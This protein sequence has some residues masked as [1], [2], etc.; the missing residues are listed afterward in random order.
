MGREIG[1]DEL[2]GELVIDRSKNNDEADNQIDISANGFPKLEADEE[3]SELPN[4]R[5]EGAI[6]TQRDIGAHFTKGGGN[7]KERRTTQGQKRG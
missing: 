6:P 5:E 2:W 7:H 1:K 4:E 3:G